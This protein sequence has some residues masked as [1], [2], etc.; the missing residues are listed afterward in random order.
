MVGDRE[1]DAHRRYGSDRDRARQRGGPVRRSPS[2]GAAADPRA[3]F[4]HIEDTHDRHRRDPSSRT[5]RKL[6]QPGQRHGQTPPD[7]AFRHAHHRRN[8]AVGATFLIRERE[9]VSFLR[10][11]LHQ[12]AL[13]GVPLKR[14][15]QPAP[16]TLGHRC[17][18]M[19]H[20]Q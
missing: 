20:D 13:D 2:S 16:D 3:A 7:R 15:Q 10:R 17:S 11:H 6:F 8:L 9:D 12:G 4:E 5:A 19:I 14:R 1:T 18:A